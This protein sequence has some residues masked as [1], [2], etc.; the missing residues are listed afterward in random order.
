V[1]TFSAPMDRV[2]TQAAFQS[3]DLPPCSTVLTWDAA[4]TVLTVTPNAPLAYA[5]GPDPATVMAKRYDIL[6]TTAAVDV[7]GVHL[8]A[9][10]QSSFRTRRQIQQRIDTIV[11]DLTGSVFDGVGDSASLGLGD[12][13]QNGTFKGLI[14]FDIT[15]LPS[16]VQ[17]EAA[18]LKLFLDGASGFP[19]P[20]LGPIL[21]D[22]VT[23]ANRLEAFNA[24]ARRS[25][26]ALPVRTNDDSGFKVIEVLAAV[27]DDQ[28]NRAT[29]GNLTQYRLS[30]T[31]TTNNNSNPDVWTFE[32]LPAFSRSPEIDVDYSLE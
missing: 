30:T 20:S 31:V 28:A 23:F 8:A 13:F 11:G 26:G 10:F 21:V 22:Q 7:N 27:M 12:T 29:L 18:T 14:T 25:L 32:D 2:A 16:G 24:V 4:G 15:A 3:A 1:I 6:V 5:T 17:L 19:L 9:T